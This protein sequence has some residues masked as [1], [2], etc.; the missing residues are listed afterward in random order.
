MCIGFD[1]TPAWK[2]IANRNH[3]APFGKTG[4]HLKV[5][6]EAVPQSIQTFRNLFAV[7]P[8]QL[9]GAPVDLDPGNNPRLDENL[10]KG[11]AIFLML[12]NRFVVKN[13]PA[14]AIS[15][16]LGCHDQLSIGPPSFLCLRNSEARESFVAGR[17]ALVHRQQAFV[18]GQKRRCNV[19]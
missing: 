18:V 12:S 3:G 13:S 4:T 11:S 8:C 7:M 1:A 2:S 6:S 16:P 14:D 17:S 19:S 15:E 5:F 9:L 10:D